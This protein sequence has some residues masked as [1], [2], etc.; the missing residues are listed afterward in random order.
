MCSSSGPSERRSAALSRGHRAAAAGASIPAAPRSKVIRRRRSGRASPGDPP[1]GPPGREGQRRRQAGSS[2]SRGLIARSSTSRIDRAAWRSSWSGAEGGPLCGSALHRSGGFGEAGERSCAA[3]TTT[4]GPTSRSSRRRQRAT[5]GRGG[6]NVGSLFSGHRR[7]RPSASSERGCAFLGRSSSTLL[8][9]R[10]RPALSRRRPIRG[11]ATGWSPRARPRRSHLR[12]LPLPRPQHR[13]QGCRDR[14]RPLG[15]LVR[16]RPDHSRASTPLRRRGERPSSPHRE[17]EAMGP[18]PNRASSRRPGRSSGMT[19]S[20]RA[21]RL[22]SSGAP[23]LRKRVWIVA[24]PARDAEA[25]AAPESGSERQRA[26][27]GGQRS[28]AKDLADADTERARSGGPGAPVARAATTCGRR[29]RGE[30]MCPTPIASRTSG[31]LSPD[32]AQHKRSAGRPPRSYGTTGPLNPPW[33][34]W[35]MGFPIGWTALPPSATPSSRRSRSGSAD[36]SS[37]TSARRATGAGELMQPGRIVDLFAGAG[38]WDEGLR[39]L[40]YTAIGIEVDRWACATRAPPGTS[41]SKPTSP[42]STQPSSRRPGG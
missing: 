28:R 41:G 34:E 30:P 38:G 18:R 24:Y 21:Y 25:G 10:P 20:G 11:R 29:W 32:Q 35:L 40:G 13:R 1:A 27:A 31:R 33:V 17:G 14:R 26:R 16:V 2:R 22:G 6:V 12:R 3:S 39:E 19:R 5:E 8:S 4:G 15:S 42:R 37:N 23:H 36:A 7:I 9:G